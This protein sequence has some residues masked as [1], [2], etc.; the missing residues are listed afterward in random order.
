MSNVAEQHYYG[1]PIKNLWLLML[2]AS[3]FYGLSDHKKIAIEKHPEKIPEWLVEVLIDYVQTRLTKQLTHGYITKKGDLT[4]VRGRIDLIQTYGKGLLDHGRVN[5]KYT[6]LSL[7]TA[8]NQYIL[9]ALKYALRLVTDQMRGKVSSLIHQLMGLG[10]SLVKNCKYQ[11]KYDRIAYHDRQDQQMISAA[12]LLLNLSIPTQQIGRFSLAMPES[13]QYWLRQLFER[14]LGGFYKA[15]LNQ[16]I[17]QVH[18]SKRLN[19]ADTIVDSVLRS[20][21]PAMQA[22]IILQ[23]RLELKNIL[24]DAKFTNIV[25]TSHRQSKDIFKSGYLYQI[26]TYLRSQ[27][28]EGSRWKFSDA[29]FIHPAIGQAFSDC[30]NIQGYRIYLCTVDLSQE[31]DVI[32]QRLLGLIQLVD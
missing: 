11:P 15:N 13:N 14:A 1:I 2:Y 32:R 19:W 30:V 5:C 17:W 9:Y 22:D 31:S 16:R 27:E 21:M 29:M 18:T 8:R 10:V 20:Y 26:Y 28:F 12:Y 6:E 4:R 25:T 24:I 23:N 7:D 3:D